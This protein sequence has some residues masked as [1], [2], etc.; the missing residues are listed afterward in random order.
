M[1]DVSLETI[2]ATV[3]SIYEAAYDQERWQDAIRVLGDIFGASRACIVQVIANP[4]GSRFARAVG[5]FTDPAFETLAVL[6]AAAEDPLTFSMAG[7]PPGKVYRRRDIIDEGAFRRRQL[8]CDWMG[9][10]QM[11][12][13]VNCNLAISGKTFWSLDVSRM[14]KFGAFQSPEIDLLQKVIPHVVRAGQI[15]EMLERA[16][17][18]SSIYANMPFG[19]LVVDVDL[20]VLH[21]NDSAE[22]LLGRRVMPLALKQGRIAVA[23]LFDA[24]RL[25]EAVVDSCRE[26]LQGAP[27]MGGTM[28]LPARQSQSA[29]P[30]LLVSVAPLPASRKYGMDGRPCAAM[31]VRELGAEPV[32][33]L[34]RALPSLFDLSPAEAKLA[35][36]LVSGKALKEAAADQNIQV[37]TA[38]R[39]LDVIFHKT[40]THRQGELIALLKA[41]TPMP[42]WD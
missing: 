7:Q 10:R 38:R 32:D 36:A 27:A 4:D 25:L 40:N 6:E 17:A 28:V 34:Q 8:W 26:P 3:G 41:S 39:Y 31:M 2:T 23:N 21:M 11:D 42:H 19:V 30:R 29:G 9:P 37:T 20:R 5:S 13:A 33:G 12:E 18:I 1:K 14:T 24:R 16:G 15:G 22:A 35:A